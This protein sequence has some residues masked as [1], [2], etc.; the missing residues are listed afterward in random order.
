VL[1]EEAVAEDL[2]VRRAELAAVDLLLVPTGPVR[3]GRPC[4]SQPTAMR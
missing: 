4:G 3:R 1:E 2:A